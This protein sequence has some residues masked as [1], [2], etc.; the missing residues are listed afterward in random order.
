MKTKKNLFIAGVL[1]LCVGFF[2]ATQIYYGCRTYTYGKLVKVEIVGIDNG[3]SQ[4][5]R[6][7][8][9]N[10]AHSFM[11]KSG[12]TND[13]I[14]SMYEVYYYDGHF[15]RTDDVYWFWLNILFV[16]VLFMMGVSFVLNPYD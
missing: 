9:Q 5:V 12:L 6:I 13:M 4:V 11:G 10:Q 14:G 3:R 2:F 8:C 1:A 15:I 7:K 16:I